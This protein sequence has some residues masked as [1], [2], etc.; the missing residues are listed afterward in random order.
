MKS[1]LISHYQELI[2]SN[3]TSCLQTK[4]ERSPHTHR[5]REREVDKRLRKTKLNRMSSWF[6]TG[7]DSA[8]LTETKVTSFFNLVYILNN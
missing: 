7:G 6:S 1:K 2:L 5:E 3:P 4:G 8:T